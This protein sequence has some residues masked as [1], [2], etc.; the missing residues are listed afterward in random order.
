ME[1]Q[2]VIETENTATKPSARRTFFMVR[3]GVNEQL[4]VQR[5]L[6]PAAGATTAETAQGA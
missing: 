2:E 1:T 4:A 6:D 5:Q 3:S